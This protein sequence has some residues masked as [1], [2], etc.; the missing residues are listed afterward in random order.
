VRIQ[1]MCIKMKKDEILMKKMR[2]MRR[3]ED[4]KG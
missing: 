2:K 4:E 1:R 3:G